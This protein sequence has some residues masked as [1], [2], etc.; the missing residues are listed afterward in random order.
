[1]DATPADHAWPNASP[2]DTLLTGISHI[3]ESPE[4][5]QRLASRDLPAL[6][7]VVT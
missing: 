2:L 3:N 1:V 6:C 4:V 5:M 7:H